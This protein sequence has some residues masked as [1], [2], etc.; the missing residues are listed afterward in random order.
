MTTAVVLPYALIALLLYGKDSRL[1]FVRNTQHGCQPHHDR[2]KTDSGPPPRSEAPV[3]SV[4]LS[5]R[6]ELSGRRVVAIL[7]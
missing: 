6:T 2:V 4:V 3:F 1:R 5:F 7:R